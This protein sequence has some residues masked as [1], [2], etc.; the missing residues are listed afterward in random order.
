MLEDG[1]IILLTKKKNSLEI[2]GDD[3]KK[4][5]KSKSQKKKGKKKGREGLFNFL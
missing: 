3:G 2:T 1:S 4:K 5:I